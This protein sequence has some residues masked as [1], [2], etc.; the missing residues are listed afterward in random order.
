[1]RQGGVGGT[2][3]HDVGASADTRA[4]AVESGRVM[5]EGGG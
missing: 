5:T 4:A 1:M 3:R 2:A